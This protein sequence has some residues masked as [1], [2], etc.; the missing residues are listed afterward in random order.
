MDDPKP[1]Q[2]LRGNNDREEVA[3]SL[4][5][6]Q[7]RLDELLEQVQDTV[8][9]AETAQPLLAQDLYD[10]FRRTQQNQTGQRLRTASELVRNGFDA[11]ARDF[12][13]PRDPVHRTTQAGTGG[14]GPE[15]PRRPGRRSPPRAR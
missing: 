2:G 12:E 6:Q 5:Q 10:S 15:C 11:Q 9:Q 8:E 3:D 1:S 13:E 14:C 4:V 7:Q